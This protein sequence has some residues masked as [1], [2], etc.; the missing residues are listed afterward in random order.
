MMTA[1]MRTL[2][3][4]EALVDLI[5]PR[6]AAGLGEAGAFVP[7]LGGSA[8]TVAV[9]AARAGAKVAL[10]GAAGDDPWGRW[11]RDRLEREGVGV[12]HFALVPGAATPV[13]FATV[14]AQGRPAYALHGDMIEQASGDLLAAVAAHDAFFLTSSTL[15]DEAERDR[16]LAARD[17]A[18]ELDQP[19]I[20]D[21]DLRP[22]R[23]ETPAFAASE[24]RE[25]VKGAFLVKAS[26]EEAR[27]LSGEDDPAAAAD[28][29]VAMGARHAVVTR[30]AG[31]AVLRGGGLRV[32]APGRPA[33]TIST[34]GAG[35]AFMGVVLA[36]LAATDFYGPA[37]AAS[38]PD[39]VA[40]AARATERWG[41]LA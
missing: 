27:L 22:H 25:L 7:H 23:W 13:V 39:A 8:A 28:G 19:V 3:L 35:D 11:I 18:L 36:G 9:T 34:L 10:A 29:L 40:A 31:G 1:S 14:D 33:Q 21:P 32:D 15:A 12:E 5:C 24:T 6:P 20:V 37:I 2:L 26:G 30:G 4:G 41:A 17:R 16:T 38:L